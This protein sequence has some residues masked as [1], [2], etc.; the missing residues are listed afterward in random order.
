[1]GGCD[2][3]YGFIGGLRDF[4]FLNKYLSKDTVMKIKNHYLLWDSSIVAYYRFSDKNF[5][6]D[7]IK[8]RY[9]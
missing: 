6:K 4:V 2:G 7:E 3:D 5:R 1:L 9:A 8:S